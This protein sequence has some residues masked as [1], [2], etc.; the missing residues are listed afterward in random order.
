[1]ADL[2][3]RAERWASTMHAYADGAVAFAHA[4][5]TAGTGSTSLVPREQREDIE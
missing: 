4:D 5:S 1:V 2:G 3:E